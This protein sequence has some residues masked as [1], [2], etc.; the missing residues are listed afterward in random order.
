M[1]SGVFA[2]LPTAYR[3]PDE[4]DASQTP[5]GNGE[6]KSI[7]GGA[8]AAGSTEKTSAN[9]SR[10]RVR[11]GG[12]QNPYRKQ[13]SSFGGIVNCLPRTPFHVQLTAGLIWNLAQPI[14]DP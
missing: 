8:N 13:F 6:C 1:V 3:K 5:N 7:D 12:S 11:L 4:F 2:G 14:Q 9:I 10:W